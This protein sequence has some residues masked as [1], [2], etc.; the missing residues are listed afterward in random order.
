VCASVCKLNTEFQCIEISIEVLICTDVFTAGL[1][2]FLF[3][4]SLASLL[5]CLLT[6]LLASVLQSCGVF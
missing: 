5:V 4:N 6:K 1:S 3:A 2:D